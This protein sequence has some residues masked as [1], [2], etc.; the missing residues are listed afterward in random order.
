MPKSS[1]IP[2]NAVHALLPTTFLVVT[3]ILLLVTLTPLLR[4]QTF[5]VLHDFTGGDDGGAP[6]SGLTPGPHGNFYGTTWSGGQRSSDC[7]DSG[8]G[9]LF[10]LSK[11][12]SG[13]DYSVIHTFL[14]GSDGAGP[15]ARV[16]F[17]PNGALFGTTSAGGVGGCQIY[18]DHLGCGIVFKMVP[19]NPVGPNTR[20]HGAPMPIT[21]VYTFLNGDDGAIPGFGDL[22][23]DPAGNMYGTTVYGGWS[24]YGA[25]YE[26]SPSGQGWTERDLYGFSDGTDGGMPYAGVLRDGRGN[27]YGGTIDGGD[28]NCWAGTCGVLY[29]LVPSAGG[30]TDNTI[31]TFHDTGAGTSPAGSLISDSSGNLYGSTSSYS[32][33]DGGT[34]FVLQPQQ[35]GWSLTVLCSFN[36]GGEGPYANLVMSVSGDLYG[37]TYGDGEFGAGTVFKVSHSSGGWTCASL[38]DFTGASDGGLPISSVSIDRQGNLY[39]TASSGGAYGQ[40][41]IWEITP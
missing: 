12:G 28:W 7:V 38:H 33:I 29:Q 22:I 25:V 27:L 34:V 30:W 4:A 14:G 16:V 11:S 19:P 18:G 39:G 17:G 8:C 24:G 10:Q 1:S 13:W 5:T 36:A 21:S 32:T 15:W 3:L 31:F 9:T 23:F 40:G 37:T 35:N 2:G 26:I 20:N 6:W 41:V